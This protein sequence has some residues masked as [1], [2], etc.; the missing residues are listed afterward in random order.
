MYT[1]YRVRI[2]KGGGK[3]AEKSV[4]SFRSDAVTKKQIEAYAKERGLSISAC[5]LLACRKMMSEASDSITTRED[6]LHDR[7]KFLLQSIRFSSDWQ[8]DEDFI[9]KEAE[10]VWQILEKS[11]LSSE[12]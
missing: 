11:M 12:P 2:G 5:I 3:M 8:S 10:S 1:V 9:K 7:M 4:I 6:A